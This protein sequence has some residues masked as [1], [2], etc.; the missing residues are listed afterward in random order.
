[1]NCPL[2]KSQNLRHVFK[3]EK[4]PVFP[5]MVFNTAKEACA[6]PVGNMTLAVCDDCG[7][8]FNETFEA[9]LLDFNQQYDNEQKHSTYYQNY[10]QDIIDLLQTTLPATQKVAE[11]GCGKGHFLEL[12]LKKGY[13]AIGFDPTYEGDNPKIVKDYFSEKY[14][15]ENADLL[16]MRHMLY[17]VL[18]PFELLHTIAKANAYKGKV[19]IEVLDFEWI[20]NQNSFCDI[21]YE[22]V[23]Y[24]TKDSLSSFFEKSTVGNLFG[25]QYIYLIADLADLCHTYTPNPKGGTHLQPTF[26]TNMAYYK[27]LAH[28][29]QPLVIWGAGGKGVSFTHLIDA[30]KGIVPCLID[31]NPSKQNR[32]IAPHGQLVQSPKAALAQTEHAFQSIFI[33][34]PNYLKEIKDM[35]HHAEIEV[36]TFEA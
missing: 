26:E 18:N 19:Y 27:E 28:T 36:F 9:N 24:F 11:I 16:V 13:D 20:S 3:V 1:M 2:C 4:M 6:A 10:L 14:S 32:Y 7:F 25:G 31:I 35:L 33:V 23:A 8:V 5:N 34:N 29:H 22:Q 15:T 12:L 17:T 21:C 30:G